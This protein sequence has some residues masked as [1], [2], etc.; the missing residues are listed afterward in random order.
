M[1]TA[2]DVFFDNFAANSSRGNTRDKDNQGD[3]NNPDKIQYSAGMVFPKRQEFYPHGSQDTLKQ[4]WRSMSRRAIKKFNRR[5]K[6][7]VRG[8]RGTLSWRSGVDGCFTGQD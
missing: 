4:W 2:V 8:V 6:V 7:H 3:D 5:T 1:K